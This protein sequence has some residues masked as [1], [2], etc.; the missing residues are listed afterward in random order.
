MVANA[1]NRSGKTHLGCL[2]S[3]FILAVAVSVGIDVADVY[4]RY[5]RLQTFVKDQVT[6]APE[7]TDD[8]IRDRLI[9]YS[10]TLGVPLGRR[11]WTVRRTWSPKEFTIS[12]QYRDTI[13]IEFL[14]LRRVFVVEF[15]PNGRG[16]L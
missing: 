8:V 6:F 5:Y 9:A 16:A 10:D 13:R 1:R 14:G 7:L 2:F 4:W 3:L 12:A 15:K 11:D